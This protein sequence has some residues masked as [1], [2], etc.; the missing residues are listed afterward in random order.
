[1]KWY[2]AHELPTQ[3]EGCDAWWFIEP[4]PGRM[5]PPME[6]RR[7]PRGYM[8][9]DEACVGIWFYPVPMPLPPVAP[10]SPSEWDPKGPLT[11]NVN[12]GATHG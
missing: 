6:L 7:I 1:M 11:I 9:G 3:Y 2:K 8:R 4:K 10:L 5:T 12:P